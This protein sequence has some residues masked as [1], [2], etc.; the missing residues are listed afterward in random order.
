MKATEE[1]Q[2]TNESFTSAH[3]GMINRKTIWRNADV[4]F[5]NLLTAF[6]RDAV[7]KVYLLCVFL[8]FQQVKQGFQQMLLL[9]AFL[10]DFISIWMKTKE[11]Q[12]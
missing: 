4:S 12:A 10:V 3:L 7:N 1:N 6:L 9:R 2:N 5:M 8:L 11:I